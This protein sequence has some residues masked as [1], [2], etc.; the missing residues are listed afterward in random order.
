MCNTCYRNRDYFLESNSGGSQSNSLERSC[1]HILMG[2][3]KKL[4]RIS[5]T[6]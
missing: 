3:V 1:E 6:V 2:S 4:T 5:G